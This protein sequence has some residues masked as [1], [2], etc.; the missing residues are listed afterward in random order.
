MPNR[1]LS[2][3]AVFSIILSFIKI[4]RMKD[5][6]IS[7]QTFKKIRENNYIYVDKTELVYEIA[8][9]EASHFFSRP[10]RF[11]KSLLVNTFKEL[12]LG[13]EKLFQGL[14]IYDKWDWSQSYP[15]IHLSFDSMDYQ[16]LGLDKAISYELKKYAKKYGVELSTENYK[17]QFKELLIGLYEKEGKI[18]LLIDE[19]DKPIIDYLEKE[20]LPEARKNQKI[21]KGFYSVLKNSEDYLRFFF[22]TGVSKFS[23]VSIFSDL[24]YLDDLTLDKNCVTLT[25]YT[26]EELEF[27]F[28]EHLQKVMRSLE[29]T[30]EE[31]LD[32]MRIR[33]NGLSWDGIHK[34]YSPY[35]IIH[36]L[37][38]ETFDNFWFTSGMP[39]FL[40][41]IMKERLIFDVDNTKV[42]T[43]DLE[44][45][46]IE[47]LDLVPL[48][49]QTG[50]LTVK[51]FNRM[52]REML[53]GYPND[54]VRESLYGFMIDS[55]A[56]NEHRSGAEITNR[57][58]LK[59]FQDADLDQIKKLI[60]SLLAGLPYEAYR[61]TAEGL[62]HGLIHFIFQL[63][64]MYIKSEVHSSKGRAD[65]I[66]ETRTHVFIFEFKFN[67]TAAEGLQQ[68]KDKK[69]ADKY[70][71]SN[72]T[73]IGI[74]VNFV[75]EDREIN[76][77]ETEVL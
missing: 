6:P 66:V 42:T 75:S 23:K 15:V 1:P 53:L 25:G 7:I 29:L 54:E 77:W 71:A 5:L 52:T 70:R 26:Q 19:Y 62:F 39:N 27:Y 9:K 61:K 8:R 2:I 37:K 17:T 10:R 74:G 76:G 67:K 59:A 51:S 18:V 33:Y 30:R 35:G 56:R 63:L 50:Y 11:G 3:E 55:I 68:I 64:G 24:N 34:V 46:D 22:I 13:N 45:Y 49:F 20:E 21:M 38:K 43:I 40:S 65:S 48:F 12:F 57:D 36:F 4:K 47:N 31:L 16:G 44:K 14:W 32:N 41:K 60:N 73:I 69:Y 28:E 58:L 72:K